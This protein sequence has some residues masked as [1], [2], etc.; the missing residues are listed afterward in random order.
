MDFPTRG[1][2]SFDV[3]T[4]FYV[5]FL[6]LELNLDFKQRETKVSRVHSYTNQTYQQNQTTTLMHVFSTSYM[7]ISV[8]SI[9]PFPLYAY[10]L[11]RIQPKFDCLTT[12]IG[13]VPLLWLGRL[14][15][16]S[17]PIKQMSFS[18]TSSLPRNKTAQEN[19]NKWYGLTFSVLSCPQ[20]STFTFTTRTI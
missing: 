14:E 16:S 20:N 10:V 15:N 1:R 4:Q 3:T 12:V 18:V 17:P 9:L 11:D 8:F 5:P 19:A 6:S 13:L 7:F 2:R